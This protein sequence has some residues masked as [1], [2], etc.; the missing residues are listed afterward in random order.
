MSMSYLQEILKDLESA[1]SKLVEI[2]SLE[3]TDIIRDATIQRFEF[4]F[5]LFW[6][7]CK[8]ILSYEGDPSTSPRNTFA[9]AYQYGLIDD[10]KEFLLML[11][12]RNKTSHVYNAEMSEQI[13]QNILMHV[14]TL[15]TNVANIIKKYKE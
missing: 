8:K 2:T 12:D 10:E 14:Q 3:K 6:K 11:D 9:K 5:E 13:Y 4:I 1:T 15:R 7:T